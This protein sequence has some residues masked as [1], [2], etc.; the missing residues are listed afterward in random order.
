MTAKPILI[1][2]IPV[3]NN[4]QHERIIDYFK[5]QGV[6][7]WHIIPLFEDRK[8]VSFEGIAAEKLEPKQFDELKKILNDL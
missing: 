2:R 3:T 6:N 8:D 1:I 5:S 4:Q 7:D